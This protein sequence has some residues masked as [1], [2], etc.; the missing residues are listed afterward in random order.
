MCS[1]GHPEFV[2]DGNHFLRPDEA[3][4]AAQEL[5]EEY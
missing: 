2:S 4:E 1:L 3:L 5:Q